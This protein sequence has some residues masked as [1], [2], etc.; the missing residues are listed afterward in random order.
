PL[1][2]GAVRTA[3][4]DGLL[5]LGRLSTR[6]QPWLADHA[7]DGTVLVPGALFAELALHAGELAGTG[8]LEELI[9][10]Q[11][12][13]LTPGEP[14]GPEGSASGGTGDGGAVEVQVA[15]GPPEQDGTRSVSVHARPAAV[16]GDDDP[17][18]APWTAHATGTLAPA[19]GRPPVRPAAW[20]PADAEPVDVEQLY[21]DL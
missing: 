3:D 14:D 20:P 19:G 16:E 9:L 12:L 17:L 11:P 7:V 5:L 4:A 1:L 13:V 18:G 8:R 10:Q 2:T 15:I 6:E 21:D